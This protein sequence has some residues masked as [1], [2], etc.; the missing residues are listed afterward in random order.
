MFSEVNKRLSLTH[1]DLLPTE[2]VE[3]DGD[4]K[5]RVATENLQSIGVSRLFKVLVVYLQYL[6]Y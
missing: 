1:Y 5:V 6:R 4:C 2:Y 3:A